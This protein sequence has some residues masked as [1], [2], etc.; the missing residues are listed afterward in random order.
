MTMLVKA[1]IGAIWS[2]WWVQKM[3]SL[4]GYAAFNVRK[5]QHLCHIDVWTVK[6]KMETSIYICDSQ[7][8]TL[9]LTDSMPV[10]NYTE[11]E[12]HDRHSARRSEGKLRGPA[13]S[14]ITGEPEGFYLWR[15]S[16]VLGMA[17]LKSLRRW[18]C[19]QEICRLE[20]NYVS[21]LPVA[22]AMSHTHT[23]TRTNTQWNV[24]H[25]A[26]PITMH[27]CLLQHG[28]ILVSILTSL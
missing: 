16:L 5:R 14:E 9:H 28:V 8:A 15:P 19:S 21:L 10:R 24:Q 17:E 12:S 22:M 25:G 27:Q 23:H 20:W 4:Y 3:T 7:E 13:G 18:L 11:R 1:S 6:I 26:S 2:I